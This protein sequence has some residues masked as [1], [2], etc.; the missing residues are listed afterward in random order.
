MVATIEALCAETHNYHETDRIIG[1]YKIENGN[2]ALPFLV[3]NQFFRIVGS[4][5]NDG[6]YIY[7]QE[8]FT[9]R[10][11]T[12]E[13]VLDGNLNWEE[14]KKNKWGELVEHDLIDEEFHGAIWPMNMPRAFLALSEEIAKYQES[15]AAK[16]SPY[17][18]ES[19]NGYYSY[20]KAN[21]S[22]NSWQSVFGSKIK[23]WKK[24]PNV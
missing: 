1:D 16:P 18:S 2:I 17:L 22:E 24:V 7:S 20:T 21:V 12:W 23:R 9:I 10:S 4:K 19:I 3:E 8:L 15:D 14:L 6:V 13:E 11:I 5:F